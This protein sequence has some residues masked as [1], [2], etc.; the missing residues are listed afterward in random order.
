[1]TFDSDFEDLSIAGEMDA[2]SC[3]ALPTAVSELEEARF[4]TT[5][6]APYV[7]SVILNK[8]GT[9]IKYM[10]VVDT[11]TTS[12]IIDLTS[13][14]Q[15]ALT[16]SD[17]LT[18][19]IDGKGV[20]FAN[21][22]CSVTSSV[23]VDGLFD[24]MNRLS[25]STCSG[26][27][28]PLNQTVP[29]VGGEPGTVTPRRMFSMQNFFVILHMKDQ[30]DE[31]LRENVM[32]DVKV[33]S[34]RCAT[35]PGFPGT[36][37]ASCG[38]PTESSGQMRCEASVQLAIDYLTRGAPRGLCPDLATAWT[39]LLNELEKV[40]TKRALF[41]PFQD[42]TL[43]L[44]PWDTVTLSQTLDSFMAFWRRATDHFGRNTLGGTAMGD[45]VAGDAA[46]DMKRQACQQLHNVVQAQNLTV[47]SSMA[48]GEDIY[49]PLPPQVLD[50]FTSTPKT[51]QEYRLVV[52]DPEQV[53]CCQKPGTCIRDERGVYYGRENRVP[54][55][56]CI[57]GT[58]LGGG[59]GAP[60]GVAF[61]SRL[62]REY[63]ACNATN[64]CADGGVCLLDSCC[65][66]NICV[67]GT[68]CHS[69]PGPVGVRGSRSIHI[70]S[71]GDGQS[72]GRMSGGDPS[73]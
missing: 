17:G 60:A 63:P 55:S 20:H 65:G 21:Q 37:V 5:R 61:R 3:Y 45:L 67:N 43:G 23:L 48:S 7:D 53:A 34:S 11:S 73:W 13:P 71:G 10:K 26:R 66:F 25:N 19:S 47:S 69:P 15:F 58:T 4:N 62:C 28:M 38:L 12:F 56:D 18:I 36:F 14:D 44:R 49:P 51:T 54:G 41:Q 22:D 46:R 35:Y 50:T 32:L 59:D 2:S 57:C 42:P 31:G 52:T 39:L 70:W 24:Q 8:E 9:D 68:E 29:A 40:V 72:N 30:C 27:A 16:N 33:G 6:T 1:M 64:P